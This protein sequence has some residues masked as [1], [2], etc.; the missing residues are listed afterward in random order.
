[1]V[2]SPEHRKSGLSPGIVDRI[3]LQIRVIREV[4]EVG[5]VTCVWCGIGQTTRLPP[6]TDGCAPE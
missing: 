2:T 3:V 4:G 1:M 5:L 6:V